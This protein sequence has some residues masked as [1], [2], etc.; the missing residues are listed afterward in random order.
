MSFGYLVMMKKPCPELTK[1]RE[2]AFSLVKIQDGWYVYFRFCEGDFYTI[3][4]GEKESEITG[5]GIEFLKSIYRINE[6]SFIFSDVLLQNREGESEFVEFSLKQI[7]NGNVSAFHIG[8]DLKFV[9]RQCYLIGISKVT[10]KGKY[11]TQNKNL[12]NRI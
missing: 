12:E 9:L 10:A 1:I 7:K 11:E 6:E 3:R 8:S 2:G 5:T 4:K